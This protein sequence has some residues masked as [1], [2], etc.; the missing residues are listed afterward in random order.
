V[1]DHAILPWQN[2]DRLSYTRIIAFGNY[3]PAEIATGNFLA[4]FS[5]CR[6]EA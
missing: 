1:T 2:R 4:W 3:A 6:R 5:S